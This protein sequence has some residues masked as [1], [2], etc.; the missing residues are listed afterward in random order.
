MIIFAQNYRLLLVMIMNEISNSVIELYNQLGQGES[1]PI[2]EEMVKKAINVVLYLHPK[3]E[4]E[5]FLILCALNLLNAAI[6]T[7]LFKDNLSYDL[8]KTNA[9]K[10]VA[11]F[12]VLKNDDVSYY[13]NKDEYCLYLKYGDVVFSFHHVPLTSE[14]LKASF[15]S[16][17][18]WPG[19][20]LQKI[21]QPLMNL[22]IKSF[23]NDI[24]IKEVIEK[25]TPAIDETG[26]EYEKSESIDSEYQDKD[27]SK[28]D[29]SS[30]N[31]VSTER[32]HGTHV[33]GTIAEGTPNNTKILAIKVG[34][35][36]FSTVA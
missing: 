8:I 6:K 3:N 33:A 17:I 21:A 2:N 25:P 18:S 1:M 32:G 26:V 23:E 28:D 36:N 14:I 35:Y 34:V 19:I 15:A 16:P 30:I 20:R 12:D 24:E 13:Y 4:D 5:V 11:V 27:I 29:I 9:A 10:L 31:D 7:E 22:A